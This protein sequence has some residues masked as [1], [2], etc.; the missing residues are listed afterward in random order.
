MLHAA[1]GAHVQLRAASYSESV[2][3]AAPLPPALRAFRVT[4]TWS[5][6]RLALRRSKVS[7][8]PATAP[9]TIHLSAYDIAWCAARPS[10]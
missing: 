7:T 3:L 4:L 8:S 1:R 9:G 10:G 5:T 6:M 2:S